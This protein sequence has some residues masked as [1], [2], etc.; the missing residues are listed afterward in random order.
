MD[1][2][3]VIPFFKKVLIIDDSETDRYIAKFVIK[4]HQFAEEVVVK[5]LATK[6]LDYLA[7]L[8]NSIEHHPQ[9]IFLDIRMPEMDGFGFLD[10]YAKL[11]EIV[12]SNCI[13]I[14]LS[15]SLDPE[16]QLRANSSPYVYRFLNKPLNKEKMEILKLEFLKK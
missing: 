5:E 14:M 3:P 4:K 10:E 2:V 8:E 7:S 12:K 15:T 9:L 16:D 13:I 1:K 11:S 6:A